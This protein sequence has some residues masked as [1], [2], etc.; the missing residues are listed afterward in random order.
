MRLEI[1]IEY[2]DEYDYITLVDEEGSLLCCAASADKLGKYASRFVK[3]IS[4]E[5]T[6]PWSDNKEL[7]E[8]F[9]FVIV[10]YD[11]DF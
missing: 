7:V 11:L 6:A 5:T 2:L 8:F 10:L 4:P 3:S 9:G 1:L